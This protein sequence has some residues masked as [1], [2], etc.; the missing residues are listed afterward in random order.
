MP[1][2]PTHVI[3]DGGV[4][5]RPGLL[6][7]DGVD[8]ERCSITTVSLRG[9]GSEVGYEVGGERGLCWL[10]HPCGVIE[11][12][13][14]LARR[15]GVVCCNTGDMPDSIWVDLHRWQKVP[16]LWLGWLPLTIIK[17]SFVFVSFDNW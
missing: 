15:A 9:T 1:R 11:L 16:T 10:I 13:R 5:S 2:T 17:G 6:I 4:I 3:R 7:V 8:D 12:G 14:L